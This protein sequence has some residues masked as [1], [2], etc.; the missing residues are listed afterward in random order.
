MTL[1]LDRQ[2]DLGQRF[3]IQTTGWPDAEA[4]GWQDVAFTDDPEHAQKLLASMGKH[5]GVKHVHLLDRW[6]EMR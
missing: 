2:G 4:M 1:P 6:K 3:V 5:P